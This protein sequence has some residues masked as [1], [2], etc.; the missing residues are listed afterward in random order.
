M[1]KYNPYLDFILPKV[2]AKKLDLFSLLNQILHYSLRAVGSTS[3]LRAG[4]QHFYTL[5]VGMT[6]IATDSPITNSLESLLP[7]PLTL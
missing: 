3:P 1:G 5:H 2:K 7:Q 4:G 6:Q